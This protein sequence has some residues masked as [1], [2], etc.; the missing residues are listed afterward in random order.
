[1]SAMES[2]VL[3][4]VALS[5]MADDSRE[6]IA[7]FVAL[8]ASPYAAYITGCVFHVDGGRGASLV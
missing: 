2:S 6:K 4:I 3:K 7:G 8:L 1:M 5:A